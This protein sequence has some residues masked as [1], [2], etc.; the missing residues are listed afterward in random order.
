MNFLE[1]NNLKNIWILNHY[2]VTPDMPGGTRHYNFAKE[3]T[4]RGY[5]VFIFASSA[6]HKLRREVKLLKNEKWKIENVKGINFV[7]LKT[8][9]Y[10]KNNWRRIVNII[11][12]TWRVIWLGKKLTKS[13]KKIENPDIIIGSSFHLLAV[14]A[15]YQLSKHYQTKFI[16]EIRDLWPQTLIDIGKLKKNNPIIKTLQLLEKFLY[17]RAE[18][19]VTLLPLAKN[20]ISNLGIN[21][22]K[23]TWI[24]NGVDL[25][26]FQNIKEKESSKYFAVFY[27][28]AYGLANALGTILD[29]A[30]IIQ[31]KKYNKIR[32]IFVGGGPEKENLINYKNK[33]KLKNI[34]LRGPVA[35]EDVPHTLSGAS[36]LIISQ[37]DTNIYQYGFSYNKLFDYLASAKPII[38]A[39]NPINDIISEAKCG[40]SIP[41]ENP[42]KM[43]R[44][45]IRLYQTSPE[46]KK[47]MGQ[48]GYEYVKKHYSISVLVDKLEKIFQQVV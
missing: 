2:A 45:I 48:N 39:G 34:E 37:Q 42:K 14:L 24:S 41:P 12:Y 8:F 29:A 1:N 20:Y 38:L 36:I 13:N 47:K 6:P 4:K 25:E 9:P 43:A 26:N 31:E 3:L 16:I 22:N 40:I 44:E 15:A 33:L 18:K 30:K 17:K 19:I 5:Q 46:K 23:I 32:F 11:S 27:V 10:N 28:G 35:K 21:E 7:W